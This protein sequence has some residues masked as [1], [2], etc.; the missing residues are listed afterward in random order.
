MESQR[1]PLLFQAHLGIFQFQQRQPMDGGARR[2][3]RHGQP[4]GGGAGGGW[5]ASG[6]NLSLVALASRTEPARR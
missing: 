1:M 4:D 5:G 3:K 6:L 2:Q